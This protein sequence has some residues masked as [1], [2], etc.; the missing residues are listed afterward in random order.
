MN[1]KHGI[2]LLLSCLFIFITQGEYNDL[3]HSEHIYEVFP[4]RKVF[5]MNFKWNCRGW[6][7]NVNKQC[8]EDSTP[9]LMRL[10]RKNLRSGELVETTTVKWDIHT[11]YGKMWINSSFRQNNDFVE[12]KIT[13]PLDLWDFGYADSSAPSTNMSIQFMGS[14][15][16][17]WMNDYQI[18]YIW[19]RDQNEDITYTTHI[20]FEQ[21][22]YFPDESKKGEIFWYYGDE[23]LWC[24]VNC[25]Q[26]HVYNFSGYYDEVLSPRTDRYQQYN[27]REEDEYYKG[28]YCTYY[29]CTRD[30]ENYPSCLM[31]NFTAFNI[32]S[33][34]TQTLLD[35]SCVNRTYNL[36][37][38]I[39]RANTYWTINNTAIEL[40]WLNNE[41]NVPVPDDPFG[42]GVLNGVYQCLQRDYCHDLRPFQLFNFEGSAHIVAA[43]WTLLA[44]LAAAT[45]T[46]LILFIIRACCVVVSLLNLVVEYWVSGQCSDHS[47]RARNENMDRPMLC[48]RKLGTPRLSKTLISIKLQEIENNQEPTEASNQADQPIRDQYFLIWF[49]EIVC[50]YLAINSLQPL[51]AAINSLSSNCAPAELWE[52]T[53]TRKHPIR[54]RHLSHVTGYQP[55]RDQYILIWSI[56]ARHTPLFTHP[57]GAPLTRGQT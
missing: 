54:T 55:I 27:L 10:Y 48:P 38:Q 6:D 50:P 32:T 13:V 49:L 28:A 33:N 14:H 41:T 53:E 23:S 30:F 26:E 8:E 43:S 11:N 36:T 21:G 15:L 57:Q 9:K 45:L 24:W 17:I 46:Y 35:L 29:N 22:F 42:V 34:K 47:S 20:K 56:W 1:W 40:L 31:L 16:R 44:I 5:K 19:L 18:A 37:E 3:L 2:Q 25:S 4:T 12:Q 7:L 39:E 51:I 52:P